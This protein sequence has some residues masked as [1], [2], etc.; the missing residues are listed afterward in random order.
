MSG[1]TLDRSEFVVLMDAVDA[2][3]VVGLNPDA[4]VPSDDTQLKALLDKGLDL[5]Q[6]RGALKV[7]DDVNILNID[8]LSMAVLMANP[9]VAVIT[10]RDNPGLGQQ[11]FLHYAAGDV[12]V[13]Q[14]LPTADQHRWALVPS[15]TALTERIVGILP[16]QTETSR[17]S[18]TLKI[19]QEEFLKAKQLIESGNTQ[20]ALEILKTRGLIGELANQLVAAI[21]QPT[22]GGTVAVLQCRQ[23]EI[24]DARNL[25]VVQGAQVAILIKQVTPGESM[26]E[27]TS[28]QAATVRSLVANWLTELSNRQN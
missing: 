16:V 17:T 20:G 19:E 21:A 15:Q 5:L 9:E 26:L 10:T 23:G 22:F 13:E 6:K 28:C 4:L 2:D 7:I 3:E 14:T 12:I 25:A 1:I 18:L 24:K 11:L 27:V 8:L